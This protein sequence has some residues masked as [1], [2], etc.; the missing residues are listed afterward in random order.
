MLSEYEKYG[1]DVL[2]RRLQEPFATR[3]GEAGR[4]SYCALVA[5]GLQRL[6]P[7]DFDEPFRLA[8]LENFGSHLNMPEQVCTT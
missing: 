1:A 2:S 8:T 5:L 6:F 4:Y 7:A 3:L